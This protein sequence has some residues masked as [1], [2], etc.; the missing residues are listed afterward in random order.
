MKKVDKII[1]ISGVSDGAI[2][3]MFIKRAWHRIHNIITY[4]FRHVFACS[5]VWIHVGRY[6]LVF[7]ILSS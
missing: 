1:F 3:A 6:S 4:I 7:V 2:R 5:C